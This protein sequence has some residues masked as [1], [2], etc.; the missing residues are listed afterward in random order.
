MRCLLVFL[1]FAMNVSAAERKPASV[2]KRTQALF[3]WFD[4]LDLADVSRAKF[5][6]IWTGESVLSGGSSEPEVEVIDGFLLADN[7]RRSA[8]CCTT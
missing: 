1:L 7:G 6:R 2:S 8:W 4:R 5:V 3:A